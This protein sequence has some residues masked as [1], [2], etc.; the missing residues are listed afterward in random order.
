MSSNVPCGA[1]KFLR[2]KCTPNCLLAP[3]FPPDRETN[4][5]YVHRLY[6]AS[7]VA[8]MLSDLNPA[9]RQDAVATLVYEA[10]ARLRDPVFGC[11]GYIGILQQR[12]TRIQNELFKAKKELATYIDRA[13]FDPFLPPPPHQHQDQH[14]HHHHQGSFPSS[15]AIDGVLGMGTVAGLGVAAPG[16]SQYPQILIPG[17]AQQQQQQPPRIVEAQQM[18]MAAFAAAREQDMLRSFE[19]QQELARFNSGFLDTGQGYNQID[20][21]AMVSAMPAGA[22]SELPL[23]PAQPFELSFA[24]HPQHYPEQQPQQQ[25]WQTQP[26]HQRARS[27]HGRSGIGPSICFADIHG[28]LKNRRET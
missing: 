3:Y 18:A 2:R 8:R 17:Q 19:Q 4:F 5:A 9:Q 13:A 27:H 7:K 15:T 10:D 20:Y 14:G 11:V 16:T 26:Q 21:G 6:G 22:P 1:C 12:L 23:V 25:Q 28:V 24:V